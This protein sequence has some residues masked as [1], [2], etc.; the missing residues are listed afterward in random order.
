FICDHGRMNYR[1]MNRGDRIEAPLVKRAGA[2]LQAVDWDEALARTASLLRGVGG[3]AMTLASPRMST[4]ALFLTRELC[5]GLDWTGAVQ[6]VMGEGAPLAG[7]RD[8]AVRPEGLPDGP[9]AGMARPSWWVLAELLTALGRKGGESLTGPGAA[10]DRLA[11][12]V[13]PFAGLSYASIGALG[14]PINPAI[15][16]TA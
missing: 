11:R 6:I 9:G 1:W 15:G 13:G 16:A 7:A 5:A 3:R 10:F 2:E 4:E 14:Q 8:L 12:S